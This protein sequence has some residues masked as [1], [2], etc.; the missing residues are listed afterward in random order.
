M[1]HSFL[2][3]LLAAIPGRWEKVIVTLLLIAVA[4]LLSHMWARYLARGEISSEKRRM[5]LVWARNVIWFVVVLVIVSVWASTIA[6]FA[7]SLAAVAGAML[8]VSK[9]LIMCVQG[10]LYATLVQPFKVGDIVEFNQLRGRVIDIDMFA[11]TLAELD[12]SGRLTGKVAEFPNGL[13]LT[14]PLKNISPTGDFALHFIRIPMPEKW[15]HGLD[16]DAL[17]QAAMAAA[18]RATSPWQ[19]EAST[20]FRKLSQ[21]SFIPFPSGRSKVSWDFSDP[22]HLVLVVRVACPSRERTQVEQQVFK[23][24]WKALDVAN[25]MPAES[26]KPAV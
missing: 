3:S 18:E 23:D 20:H 2:D 22:K 14:T 1:P 5:H 6:G 12:A 15:P 16:L 26:K 4:L 10:Y 17:E 19:E 25:Q 9:E 24:T 21:E 11:T 8:I 13:L 7:L